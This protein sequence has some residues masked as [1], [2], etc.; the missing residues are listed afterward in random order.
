MM[1]GMP[2]STK[3]DTEL[4]AAMSAISDAIWVACRLLVSFHSNDAPWITH[5]FREVC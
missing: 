5:V 1:Y 4:R 2:H 3:S